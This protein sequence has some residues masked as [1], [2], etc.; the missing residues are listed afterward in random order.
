MEAATLSE[1]QFTKADWRPGKRR[2]TQPRVRDYAG[3][4]GSAG[5]LSRGGETRR[6]AYEPRGAM[7]GHRALDRTEVPKGRGDGG[8]RLHGPRRGARPEEEPALCGDEDTGSGSWPNAP[9]AATARTGE[10]SNL[11]GRGGRASDHACCH[12]RMRSLS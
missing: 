10:P 6:P 8:E 2:R 1:T 11:A 7:H 9:L 12:G 5:R 3:T 4:E